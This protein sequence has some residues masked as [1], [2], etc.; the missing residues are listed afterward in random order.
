[1]ALEPSRIEE[2]T[3]DARRAVAAARMAAGEPWQDDAD[4]DIYWLLLR[5]EAWAI[6]A[7]VKSRG[8]YEQWKRKHRLTWRWR[9][10]NAPQRH[11]RT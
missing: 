7:R 3:A 11:R 8:A 4:R 2:L 10:Y 9:T 6:L 1:M 5:D